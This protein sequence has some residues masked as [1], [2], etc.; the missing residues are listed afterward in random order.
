VR[1]REGDVGEVADNA[2][3]LSETVAK[4]VLP[5]APVEAAAA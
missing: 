1:P 2:A 5:V 4:Y 3:A